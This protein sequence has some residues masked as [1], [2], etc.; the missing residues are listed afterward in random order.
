MT[1]TRRSWITSLVAIACGAFAAKPVI[2]H[3]GVDLA[4]RNDRSVK[5][6]W[7]VISDSAG[8]DDWLEFRSP[9]IPIHG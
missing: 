9:E 6:H 3:A 5:H 1:T 7:K 2:V 4:S 8:E